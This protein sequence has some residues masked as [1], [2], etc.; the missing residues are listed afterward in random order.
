[1]P[2]LCGSFMLQF[3][4]S[5]TFLFAVMKEWLKSLLAF[6]SQMLAL[7]LESIN[8]Q[9]W[10]WYFQW[11]PDCDF[12]WLCLALSDLQWAY[13]LQLLINKV[14]FQEILE[15]LQTNLS[16]S[17]T[18]LPHK[19]V[20]FFAMIVLFGCLIFLGTIA[21]VKRA[22]ARRLFCVSWPC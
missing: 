16:L 9:G 10:L 3:L 19:T 21:M 17:T 20:R 15:E 18:F 8:K 12:Q 22:I 2:L 14:C 13:W 1:M 11:L 4:L 7:S 6:G 5:C